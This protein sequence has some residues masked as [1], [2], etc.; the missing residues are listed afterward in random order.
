MITRSY[1]NWP[2]RIDGILDEDNP[3]WLAPDLSLVL[4]LLQGAAA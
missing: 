2:G 3:G 4:N 1:N